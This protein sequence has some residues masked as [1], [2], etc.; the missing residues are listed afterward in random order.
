MQLCYMISGLLPNRE[1]SNE[2]IDRTVVEC[3]F[4]IVS[5]PRTTT[6]TPSVR[7]EVKLKQIGL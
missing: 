7:D 5:I 2:E 3:V 6:H 4:M 1:D